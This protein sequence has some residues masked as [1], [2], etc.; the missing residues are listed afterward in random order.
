MAFRRR[1]TISLVLPLAAASLAACGDDDAG[2]AERFCGEIDA[3]RAALTDPS[4]E[5]SDDIEPFL[6]LYRSIGDLAP[7]AIETEWQQ[8]I[9]NY[10]TV[11]TVVP[12]DPESEEVAV[13]TALQTEQSAA[14]VDAWLQANCGIS[15][16]PLSTLVTHDG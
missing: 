7:L 4:L 13:T 16:G 11:S 5:Y 3:N 15:I 1:V 10:E 12:G 14:A 6:D 8:L 2:D 9:T